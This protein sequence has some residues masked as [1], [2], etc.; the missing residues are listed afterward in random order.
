MLG[1]RRVVM[2]FLDA[3]EIHALAPLTVTPAPDRMLR[4]YM[5]YAV[6]AV[7]DTAVAAADAAGR[8][9][10]PGHPTPSHFSCD[11]VDG[12]TVVEWGGTCL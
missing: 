10:T 11:R 7:A 6:D 12:T 4:V 2:R 8:R 9:V 1:A 5:V 3:T